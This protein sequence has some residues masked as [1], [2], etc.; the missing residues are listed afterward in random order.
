MVVGVEVLFECLDAYPAVLVPCPEVG[1]GELGVDVVA[2]ALL[3]GAAD[4]GGDGGEIELFLVAEK[5]VVAPGDAG[6][7][8]EIGRVGGGEGH[9]AR[10][11]FDEREGDGNAAVGAEGFAGGGLDGGEDA[12]AGEILAGGFDPARLV[13]LA[14]MDCE[15]SPDEAG[16][17]MVQAEQADVADVDARA[18]LNG[19]DDVDRVRRRVLVGGGWIDVGEGVPGVLEAVEQVGAGGEHV[20]GDGGIAPV[21]L[22]RVACVERDITVE[23][24]ATEMKQR[25]AVDGDV[26]LDRLLGGGGGEMVRQSWVVD[27]GPVDGDGDARIVVAEAAENGLELGRV[28]AGAS[29]ERERSGR[30]GFA[31][32]DE[33][34]CAVER[35]V[36]GAVTGLGD[37]DGVGLRV[38]GPTEATGRKRE[39]TGGDHACGA[40]FGPVSHSLAGVPCLGRGGKREIAVYELI[41]RSGA[42]VRNV[43]G[44]W[45]ETSRVTYGQSCKPYLDVSDAV[46][47]ARCRVDRPRRSRARRS[48]L[49][50][51]SAEVRAP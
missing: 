14:G 8:A 29:D 44:L 30:R 43:A 21:E 23:R 27:A 13:E 15:P 11:G 10:R 22:D 51:G 24:D 38:G 47:N 6:A 1:F 25:A 41:V 16:V 28:R 33:A 32:G 31:Q 12:G 7:A 50:D 4:A 36:D 37:V 26:D 20:G 17:H 18:G 3:G 42:G 39:K 34:R 48:R 5:I 49:P 40:L 46:A 9:G 35:A 2:E 19:E 45:Q